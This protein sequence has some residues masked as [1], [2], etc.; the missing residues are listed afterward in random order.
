MMTREQ[1]SRI[2]RYVTARISDTYD[3]Q[4]E[5]LEWKSADLNRWIYSESEDSQQ[6]EP[7]LWE[8]HIVQ[9]I[10]GAKVY[11]GKQV[12][13]S[14]FDESHKRSGRPKEHN[15]MSFDDVMGFGGVDE[16]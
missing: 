7:L 11:D 9:P 16:K 14:F 12:A 6:S 2:E 8:K 5:V 13:M 4:K 3:W 1:I 10:Y 15:E